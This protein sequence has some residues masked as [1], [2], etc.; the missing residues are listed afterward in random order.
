MG[1]LCGP[2]SECGLDDRSQTSECVTYCSVESLGPG[3]MV[4]GDFSAPLRS[5]RNDSSTRAVVLYPS[6]P[7]SRCRRQATEE[8][9]QFFADFL[10]SILSPIG[11][12]LPQEGAFAACRRRKP[13]HPTSPLAH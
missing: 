6:S 2:G 9:H 10:G 8:Q 7:A 13:L 3:S 5:A 12:L 4:P 11:Q 1:L